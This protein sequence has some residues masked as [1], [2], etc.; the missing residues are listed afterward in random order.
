MTS[1]DPGASDN[2]EQPPPGEYN[3]MAAAMPILPSGLKPPQPLKTDGNLATNW[4]RFKRTWDNYSIV[5][6][7]ERFDEKFK[8]AMFLSVIGEDAMEIFDGMDFTLETDRQ[9]LSKVV[10]KFEEFCIGETNE[11]YERFIFNRRNQEENES[12]DQYVTV[13]R[14]LAQTCNFCSCLQDSLIRDR[15]VLGIRDES[16]RKKLLQEKKLNLSRAVDIGR[17][18]ETTSMRLKELKNKAVTSGTDEEINTLKTKR[19]ENER[20]RR[21]RKTIRSCRYCGGSHRRGDCPAYGQTCKKCGRRNHFSQ[22]CLQRNSSQRDASANIVTQQLSDDDSGDSIMTLDLSP[23]PAEEVLVVQSKQ[24]KSKIHATMKIKGGSET[25]FQ[26]DTGATCNVIRSGELRG[27]KYE[28]NVTATNQVLKMYNSSPLK[29]AGKC[30]VQLTNPRNSQKYKVDFVVVED[31]DA[32]INLLGSRAAQQMNL[33][34][35]NHENM[36]PGENEV[37]V[38]QTPSEI[39]LSEEEIRTKYADVFQGLGE[40]GEPLHLEVD[41]MITPVQIP[42][43]RIPEALKVPLK[44][45]LAELEQQGVIEKVTQA[46]EWVSA[47]VV[48]KKSNGKIR[49]CLDPQPLNKALKRCHYPIPTIEEVLPDL[50]NAKVFTKLDCKNGY[51]QVKLDQDS[52]ILTTFNTPFGRYKWTR[53]PFGISPAGEIF[54]RRLDQAIEGLGGVRTVADDLL[55]IGNGESVVDAVKDHD[56]KLEA[57]L[58]RC[59]ERG[60]KLNETKIALKQTSMPYIGH[61]LTAHGVKA[62]PSKVDAITNLTKPTDVQGVRRILGMTNYLAKFLPKLSD[63]SAPLRE[64]TR[65]DHDFYWSDIHD[66][67]F[68]DIKELVSSPPLLKYYEPSKPLV[69]QCDAS[70]KGLGASL[71]QDG[72]PIAYASRALT[73]TETNYAQIEKELLAI[74]FGVERFHQYTYGR[75][76]VVDSDHKPLETIFGKPLATAPRRLQ[77]MFMRLQRYD[78]DIHYKKGSEMYLADTLSRHF[79]GDEVHVVRSNFEE[80]IEEMPKIEDI[81]QMVASE[82][83]MARLKDETSKDEVLQAVKAAIQRGWP[84]SKSSLPAAVTPYFQFRDELVAQEGL[85]LRGDRVVIPHTLRKETIQ[86]LHAAHQGIES[87]LRRARE[88][89]YWPNMNNEVKDYISRCDTCLTYAPRQQKE[90]L[91]SHEV[92][93]RPWAKVATDLFQFENKDYLVTVDYFSDFFEVDRLYSTTS[94]TVIKKLKGHFAR[95]GIPDEV[96]SDNGSQFTAEEFRVFAQAYGFKHT[97]TSPH[98]P[99]SNGKAESA[100]KQAKKTLR[101][102]RVSGNDFYLALL[103]VRNTPQEGYNMSPAQRMMSRSTKTLLPVSTSLLKPHVVQNTMDIILKKQ[104]KQQHYYNRGAKTLEQLHKGDRVKL[105][106]FTLGKKDWADGQ[107]VKEVRPRS[108]E[109]QSDGKVYIRNRRHLRKYEHIEDTEP[110]AE[111]PVPEITEEASAAIDAEKGVSSDGQQGESGPLPESGTTGTSATRPDTAHRTR[112]GRVPVRPARFNDFIMD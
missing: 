43:R 74:V 17:S 77:K 88:S 31:K 2:T 70:E 44:D 1:T 80:E 48:N 76:V 41:E 111:P 13:L 58:T 62:D 45:H 82:D 50:S 102:A 21:E 46:T 38:V 73:S 81:N 67:A 64:L 12:I 47:I 108:Y 79:S 9:L 66:Q 89:I 33:I 109:V 32:N 98:H 28:N 27:T 95:Y 57:L 29:P 52:S 19:T 3:N 11:T 63:V 75:K 91:L 99:Q 16:I 65:K 85:I 8:T 10:E 107:V 53:M 60:I 68:D 72:N 40:L 87:T 106:P 4:K 59:R 34:R 103:N 104:A 35:V 112:S 105:Q 15:L 30:R 71:L 93:D 14:K 51:W 92:P 56:T 5:A 90:P 7:L 25:I 96:I 100:V 97:S 78:L 54:Q 49:L 42:P 61:L 20:S 83:K 69:L 26:V 24:L 18:G 86:D 22:V 55:I 101:M 110:P 37:H 23:E 39:G 84:E 6:R 36:L 94:E